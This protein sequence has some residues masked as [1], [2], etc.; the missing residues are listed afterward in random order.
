MI[1]GPPPRPVSQ[2]VNLDVRP[3]RPGYEGPQLT[4]RHRVNGHAVRRTK[5]AV[6]L[7]MAELRF[8]V[9]AAVQRAALASRGLP[10]DHAGGQPLFAAE[11]MM[12]SRQ[13]RTQE[14]PCGSWLASSSR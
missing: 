10:R 8:E 6:G 11:V 2:L 5:T 1:E 3:L 13:K 9:F 7:S 12:S 4:P 14:A